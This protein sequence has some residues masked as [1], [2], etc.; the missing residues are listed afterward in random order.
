MFTQ[1]VPDLVHG[2]GTTSGLY[3]PLVLTTIRDVSTIPPDLTSFPLRQKLRRRVPA[4]AV[5]A[6]R[7]DDIDGPV[8]FKAL[9]EEGTLG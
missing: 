6:Q 5:C 1:H 8:C 3:A 9:E 4:T 7:P 2:D